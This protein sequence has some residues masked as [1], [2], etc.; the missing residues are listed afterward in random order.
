MKE[1]TKGDTMKFQYVIHKLNEKPEEYGKELS[2][3]Q[4]WFYI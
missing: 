4:R 3:F 1:Q 2:K